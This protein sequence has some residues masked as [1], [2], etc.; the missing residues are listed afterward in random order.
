MAS[1]DIVTQIG[2]GGYGQVFLARKK[3][4]KELC[5][6]KKM[7]KKLLHK[8]GEVQHIWTERDI[9]TRTA[10]PWLVKLLYAFQDMDNVYL[11]M[12]YA[13]GGDMRTLL[14]VSGRLREEHARYYAAEMFVAIAELHRLGYIHRDLKPENFLIDS[15]G[16]LKLTDFGL[17]RGTMSTAVVESLRIKLEKIRQMPF[18]YRST[19]ERQTIHKSIRKED[20][21]AFSLV[22]SPD[23][24]AP[25]VLLQNGKGY[26]LEVDY[27]SAGCILFECLA[28]LKSETDTFYFDDFNDPEDMAKYEAVR[29]RVAEREE[30]ERSEG[31]GGGGG[32]DGELRKAFVGFTFK[33]KGTKEWEVDELYTGE[34]LP[35][36]LGIR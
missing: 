13:P 19:A 4:T 12:E 14:N 8:L 21:Q 10:S 17:S 2:Q 5:A 6:L 33:H 35:S 22:G 11:A 24:M 1:F 36:G 23:Y 28:E 9:L 20:M 15:T 29:E 18:T 30:R 16:N 3:D 32:G 26:G 31:K 25:E 34:G 7:S 27:W